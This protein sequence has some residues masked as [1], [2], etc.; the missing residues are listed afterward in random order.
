MIIYLPVSWSV[1][2]IRT[3]EKELP[4]EVYD[5]IHMHSQLP[6]SWFLTVLDMIFLWRIYGEK[7]MHNVYPLVLLLFMFL[8]KEVEEEL[9][10]FFIYVIS[11][12]TGPTIEISRP[13]TRFQLKKKRFWK[14]L[15]KK[16]Q[17]E[18][19]DFLINFQ[20]FVFF[21]RFMFTIIFK[22]HD[23]TSG[24]EKSC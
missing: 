14:L 16:F 15:M 12:R 22:K 6:V 4:L 24:I 9:G 18:K 19:F 23:L 1:H 5:E 7:V 21:V 17:T 2:P 13:T 20:T 11:P 3:P 8:L 10:L